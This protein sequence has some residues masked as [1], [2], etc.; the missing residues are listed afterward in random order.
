MELKEKRSVVVLSLIMTGVSL[1]VGFLVVVFLYQ[2]AFE[3]ERA[4]LFEVVAS[5][6]Y[7]IESVAR[8]DMEF[9]K[10]YPGGP[11]VATL[12]Q[13][14][15][16]HERYGAFGETGEFLVGRRDDQHILFLLRHRLRND[17]REVPPVPW[18]SSLAEPMRRALSGQA[19]TI[20]ASDYKGIKVLAAYHPVDI[21]NVGI[22]TK[23]DVS[24]IRKPF[25]RAAIMAIGIG[26]LFISGGVA[27]FFKVGTPIISRIQE[28]NI[29]LQN[30]SVTIKAI[31]K[32]LAQANKELQQEVLRR[33]EIAEALRIKEEEVR[34]LLNSTNEAIYGLDLQGK[35]T[36][37]NKSFLELM[38]YKNASEL[39]GKNLHE[40]IHHTHTNDTPY[41]EEEC[42]ILQAC[43]GGRG[44]H[45]DNEF[46]W[47]IDG[48]SVA[49]EYWAY[50]IKRAGETIG[51]VVTFIDITK[52]RQAEAEIKK[53]KFISDNATDGYFLVD[54]EARFLYVNRV[55]CE[56]L[57]YSE[58]ELLTLSVPDVDIVYDMERY[59][60]LFMLVQRA[61]IS[62]I[63]TMN[64]RKDGTIFPAEI[65]VTGYR[66]NGEAYL[67]A[68]LRDVTERKKADH[69]LRTAEKRF[70]QL[71]ESLSDGYVGAA[72]DGNLLEFNAAYKNMLGY[73]ADA[74][75]RQVTYQDLTP[76]KWHAMEARIVKEQIL[77]RGYSGTY[78][79]EYIR[80]DGTV[81]PIELRAFLF[82]NDQGEPESM[83]AIVSDISER[84][85]A[86]KQLKVSLAEKEVLLKEIHHRVKN[87]M[88]IISSLLY[89]QGQKTN[90]PGVQ[91]MITESYDRIRSMALIHDKLYRSD[92]LAK[93]DFEDYTRTLIQQISQSYTDTARRVKFIVYPCKMFL[94]INTAIPCGLI[95]NELV[96]NSLKHAFPESK[97]GEID[98]N[99]KGDADGRLTL[100]VRD[101]GVGLP[102]NVDMRSLDTLGLN[103]V[104]NL[105]NQ[106]EASCE[107]RSDNGLEYR[108]VFYPEGLST[109]CPG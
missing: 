35:C 47:R 52:R 101:N 57:G 37:V 44:I 31:N 14:H 103:L 55:A 46:F 77:G 99:C 109:K 39:V 19:G 62:P 78:E 27:L 11:L 84:K 88:Q 96:T 7:L 42:R 63:E 8:F 94:P 67:F 70:N 32:S 26:V 6:A 92:D 3:E 25:V 16:A 75:L 28:Q 22:V 82:R 106:M 53:F 107:V 1:V 74:E 79:K 65:T 4:R 108:F 56:K 86:E 30:S 104:K 21:L 80:K 81:F 60:E 105:A 49:V 34:L 24:E 45:E 12:S 13:I 98:I 2:S 68:A 5:Q 41:P 15:D 36:M 40:L 9:S 33:K 29:S 61:R 43:R 10:D 87:N 23:I 18:E 100:I 20:V 71:R 59:K 66:F 83:W 38:G 90:A 64:K 54:E 51:V 76:E 95:I 72:L 69:A 48:S 93:I 58:K 17:G 50:P 89:L 73:Q 91:A 97:S 85:Q 102:A